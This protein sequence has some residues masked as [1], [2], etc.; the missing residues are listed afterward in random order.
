MWNTD[1]ID[2]ISLGAEVSCFDSILQSRMEMVGIPT[3]GTP[4]AGMVG[5]LLAA[6]RWLAC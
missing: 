1:L 2:S 6:S 3:A 5:G 4:M